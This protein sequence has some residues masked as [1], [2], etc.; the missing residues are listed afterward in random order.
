MEPFRQM[1]SLKHNAHPYG[2]KS[3]CQ[4]TKNRILDRCM[5]FFLLIKLKVGVLT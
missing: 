3:W 2:F 1:C 4:A 5:T